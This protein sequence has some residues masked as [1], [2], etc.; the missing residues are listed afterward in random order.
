MERVSDAYLTAPRDVVDQPAFVNAAARVRT[1]LLPPELLR[2]VKQ[3][4]S[5]LGRTRGARFGPRIIDI[6]LLLWEG[7]SYQ[8]ATLTIPHPRLC[9]RRFAL[10]PVL[11]IDPG[12]QLPD[13]QGLQGFAERLSDAADQ[14]VERLT[15]VVL[16]PPPG[17]HRRAASA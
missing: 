9:E 3:V 14:V 5:A 16:W 7:G 4:E 12:A 8:D 11:Q 2:A 10:V 6:D 13:G 1:K 15:G 17:P